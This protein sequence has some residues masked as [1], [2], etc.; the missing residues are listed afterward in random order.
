ME[1]KQNKTCHKYL[2]DMAPLDTIGP[3]TLK[4]FMCF[5][6][7]KIPTIHRFH[8]FIVYYKSKELCHS[9]WISPSSIEAQIGPQPNT[10]HDRVFCFQMEKYFFLR[11]T[12]VVELPKKNKKVSPSKLK[13][14]PKQSFRVVSS[15]CCS[16]SLPAILAKQGHWN[17][18]CASCVQVRNRFHESKMT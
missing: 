12:F 5:F 13:M 16:A 4:H 3:F 11:P 14:N 2:F 8:A 9:Q 15:S 6:Q 18:P 7:R 17:R 1:H 10:L